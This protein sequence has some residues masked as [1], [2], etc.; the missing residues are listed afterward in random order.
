MFYSRGVSA[1]ADSLKTVHSDLLSKRLLNSNA[2]LI[3]QL[4][5]SCTTRLKMS[6]P[7]KLL[8]TLDGHQLQSW[9]EIERGMIVCVSTGHAFMSQKGSLLKC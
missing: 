2:V 1:L 9:E 7:A 8:Y 3:F 5:D 6:Q 4:L